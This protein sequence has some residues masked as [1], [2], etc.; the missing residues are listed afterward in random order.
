[1]QVSPHGSAPKNKQ[2]YNNQQVEVT[3]HCG[4]Q[5]YLL[6]K[7][8]Y[9]INVFICSIKPQLTLNIYMRDLLLKKTTSFALLKLVSS[10]FC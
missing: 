8:T 1:M 2:D 6:L 10:Y 4:P 5:R 7:L 3:F 9:Q